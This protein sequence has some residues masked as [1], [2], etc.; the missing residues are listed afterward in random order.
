MGSR[1]LTHPLIVQCSGLDFDGAGEA[2][3]SG[4][5]RICG[6]ERGCERFG[7]GD[8]GGVI[9]SE[10]VPELPASTDQVARRDALQ[11]KVQK[12]SQRELRPPGVEVTARE[13][14]P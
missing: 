7:E 4:E 10:V 5:L 2:W 1:A 8:I 13:T 14:T 11:W 6:E 12:I 9:D 3:R